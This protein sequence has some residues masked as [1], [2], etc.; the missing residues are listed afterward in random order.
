[1]SFVQ[2]EKDER[3]EVKLKAFD[4][5]LT[6]M[7]ELRLNCPWDKKQT[8]D[9]IRHLTIEETY[10]L[11]EAILEADYQE[12]KNEIG[13]IMLH[14]LFYS[15]IADEHQLFDIAD[16]LEGIAEKMVRRHP[17]VY[18]EVDVNND[19]EVKKNW[20]K[21]KQQEKGKGDGPKR[22]LEGVPSA[23]P[24]M[25]K[26]YRIQEKAKGVGFQ[27]ETSEGA[28]DKVKEE[29][30]ELESARSLDDK[31]DEFG[32]VL[33][34]L[35]NYARYLGIDPEKALTR[36]NKKF[37]TRFNHVEESA[38]ASRKKLDDMTLEEMDHYWNE[39]RYGKT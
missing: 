25:V 17:H 31:E 23:L 3:R 7:D 34:S 30:S 9:S 12:V 20:E 28:W 37:I 38:I 16:V 1:M 29:I 6:I 32:D 19:E 4:R 36:T 24:A 33:F 8:I 13:D 14:L 35:I 21:I 2:P 26:A 18:G 11:S 5:L 22:V 15:R 39:A 10:E 27:W